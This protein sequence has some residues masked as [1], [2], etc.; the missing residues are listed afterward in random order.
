MEN[1]AGE[2]TEISF[3]QV[4]SALPVFTPHPESWPLPTVSSLPEFTPE[5]TDADTVN[6]LA[7]NQGFTQ[8]NTSDA[9][10]MEWVDLEGD[11]V[12]E[13]LASFPNEGLYI[14][15]QDGTKTQL[16]SLVPN[17]FAPVD[18]DGDGKEELAVTFA[19]FGLF[20]YRHEQEFTLIHSA[21]PVYYGAVDFDGDGK[22]GVFS[23]S[24]LGIEF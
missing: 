10:H 9:I 2:I 16:H 21:E 11:K 12:P 23:A 19:Q 15:Y 5:A 18:L 20:I 6:V 4:I 13:L 8:I 17:Y 3:P 1:F 22:E 24:A 14:H 7:E